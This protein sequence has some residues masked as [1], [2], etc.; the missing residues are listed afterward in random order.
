MALGLL[1]ANINEFGKLCQMTRNYLL[2]ERR[3]QYGK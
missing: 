3:K 1:D 2:Y